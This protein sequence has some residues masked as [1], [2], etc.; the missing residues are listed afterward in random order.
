[1]T[2]YESKDWIQALD[3]ELNALDL[4]SLAGKKILVTGSTGLICSAVIDLLIR[5]NEKNNE[6]IIIAAAGREKRKIESRFGRFLEKE[7]FD[8]AEYDATKELHFDGFRYDFIIHGAGNAAPG[9][10]AAEP[11]ET[12][13]SN[14]I[15]LKNLLDYAL[16]EGTERVLYISSSEVYGKKENNEP[17]SEEEYGFV[18]ILNPRNS[19]SVGKRAAETLCVSYGKEYGVNSVIV[20]PGHIYGPTATPTDNR[21]SSAWVYDVAKGKNIVMKSE[22]NQIR[23]YCHCLD[24]ATA[25]LTVLLK[26][27][28]L[29]AYNISNPESVITIKQM[30]EILTRVSG[31]GLLFELPTEAEKSGFNPMNNS[32]LDSISLRSL[33]WNGIFDAARGF[34]HTFRIVKQL[35]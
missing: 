20:R 24:C 19:Y 14:F 8:F 25:I 3:Q 12:M 1:M 30:A 4:H 26:G 35:L 18:D 32:S 31:T 10:I 29:K 9:N 13:V 21:V 23:S 6:K 27:E 17:F 33:G 5:W 34:D 22:G 7:W 28:S 2:I 11:V 15:G 16:K